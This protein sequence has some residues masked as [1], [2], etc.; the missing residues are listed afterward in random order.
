M[1]SSKFQKDKQETIPSE[2]ANLL[3]EVSEGWYVPT[4]SLSNPI[5]VKWGDTDLS[6][7]VKT[8]SLKNNKL[9]VKCELPS[10]E[11]KQDPYDYPF[12]NLVG[13]KLQITCTDGTIITARQAH[14]ESYGFGP[15][16]DDGEGI[17]T[18]RVK[19]EA[20]EWK[21]LRHDAKPAL[22]IGSIAGNQLDGFGN[23]ILKSE[24]RNGSF[25]M[26]HFCLQ[27]DRYIYYILQIQN[28]HLKQSVIAINTKSADI[29]L[30]NV[31]ISIKNLAFCFGQTIQVKS[32]H[33]LSVDGHI[34]GAIGGSFGANYLTSNSSSP[35]I[36]IMD[37]NITWIAPF[38]R[39]LSQCW[40]KLGAVFDMALY[41]YIDSL[42]ETVLDGAF[43]KIMLGLAALSEFYIEKTQP[44]L[45]KSLFSN[46]SQW[47]KI[48][49]KIV[50][51]ISE[52]SKPDLFSVIDSQLQKIGEVDPSNAIEICLNLAKIPI[53]DEVRE[54]LVIGRG[55]LRGKLNTERDDTYSQL[56]CLR[57]ILVAVIS[58]F[59]QYKGVI[60]GWEKEEPYFFFQ[61]APQT[62]WHSDGD[63]EDHEEATMTYT[64]HYTTTETGAKAQ[65]P[66][67]RKL[68]VPTEGIMGVFTVFANGLAN[69]TGNLV[70]ATIQPMPIHDL[71]NRTFDFA[72]ML[73]EHPS[74][75]S[76]LFTIELTP[77]NV[78]NIFGW[79][80]DILTVKTT[81]ELN[82][83]L[84]EVAGSA[85]VQ[86]RIQ[87]L[88]QT[89]DV[90]AQGQ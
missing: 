56:A 35:P 76:V 82:S 87:R 39:K 36:P 48:Y 81:K 13:Q 52:I 24:S 79:Q 57:A 69:K 21:L 47:R 32:L 80:D 62:W 38:Y 12:K 84:S 45:L 33:A 8:A 67:F 72:I 23:L 31:Y 58:R 78:I 4:I 55:A 14:V 74:V 51:E 19:I 66:L 34:V 65:W 41:Y 83:F 89:S 29:D 6:P 44:D 1:I 27:G 60:S 20:S 3:Y 17:M 54:A 63:M 68:T 10:N 49:S 11:E 61:P 90:L 22:W 85:D 75:K 64:A 2:I 77:D 26:G 5:S 50:P 46:R 9:T 86:E 40:K 25:S 43:V 70:V 59:I 88:M 28:E 37:Y 30:G 16:A 15:P 42:G 71:Q 73:Q 53:N 7:F 18:E